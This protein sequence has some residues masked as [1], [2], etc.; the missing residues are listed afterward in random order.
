MLKQWMSSKMTRLT[1]MEGMMSTSEWSAN[2]SESQLLPFVEWFQAIYT[3]LTYPIDDIQTT[4]P[5]KLKN[6]TPLEITKVIKG[7]ELV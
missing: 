3:L 2:D 7:G 5:S 4:A 6:T 1:S